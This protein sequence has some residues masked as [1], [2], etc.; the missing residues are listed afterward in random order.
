M[1]DY[2]GTQDEANKKIEEAH[3]LV[4]GSQVNG[5][6]R[7]GQRRGAETALDEMQKRHGQS[8][9][10]YSKRDRDVRI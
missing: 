10:K 4:R 7:S 3:K 9:G 5:V 2:Q 6:A 1:R 8:V